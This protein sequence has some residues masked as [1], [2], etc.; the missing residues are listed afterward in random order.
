VGFTA[1]TFSPVKHRVFLLIILLSGLGIL[2]LSAQEALRASLA[3]E[4][5]AASRKRSREGVPY[6]L[7]LD[8]VRLRFSAGVDAEYNDNVNLA[9]AK[10]VDDFILRPRAGIEA[11]WVVSERNSL[12]LRLSLGYEHYLKGARPSRAIVT[13]DEDSGLFFDIFVGDFA[14]TMRD[15]FSLSQETSQ[16]PS[17]NGL[18]DIFRLENTLGATVAWDLADVVPQ[19]DYSHY[20]YVPLDDQYRYLRH[21]AD[22]LTLRLTAFL[23]PALSTGLEVGTGQTAYRDAALSDNSHYSYGPFVRYQVSDS[24]DVRGSF[25]FAEYKFD[26]SAFI[27]NGSAQSSFYADVAVTHQLTPRTSHS[28]SAGESLSTDLNGAPIQLFYVRW[29]AALNIIQHW[30]FRLNL[31]YEDG[32]ETRGLT[33]EDFTRYGGGFAVSREL[34][35]QLSATLDYQRLSKQSNGGNSDYDQNRLVLTL[36]YQF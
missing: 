21:E 24:I 4:R 20:S 8:P 34:T 19:L 16:D 18:A 35:R 10:P 28:L 3:S 2:S 31:L 36:F 26:P 25:G 11:I 32:Q 5:A 13:G 22:R 23:N 6:N 9:Q 17:A 29:A 15:S 12:D 1:G 33:P 27:T 7:D 14:I 30:S